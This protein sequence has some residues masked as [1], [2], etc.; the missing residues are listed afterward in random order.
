MQARKKKRQA[1]LILDAPEDLLIDRKVRLCMQ[2]LVCTVVYMFFIPPSGNWQEAS[3]I[4]ALCT[5]TCAGVQG[6]DCEPRR[7][8]DRAPKAPAP[9]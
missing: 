9:E 2:M 3:S 8:D 1:G 6:L 7:F 4:C 5:C